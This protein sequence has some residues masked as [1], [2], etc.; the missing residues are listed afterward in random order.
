MI[1]SAAAADR[2]E[3]WADVIIAD[4]IKRR[5]RSYLIEI[6]RI[7]EWLAAVGIG[8]LESFLEFFFQN[9]FAVLHRRHF[10]CEKLL[11]QFFLLVQL[12]GEVFERA[13]DLFL[14]LMR[15]N[16]AGLGID[17]KGGFA[18]RTNYVEL[19]HTTQDYTS[20]PAAGFIF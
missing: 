4:A 10:L 16:G 15:E 3:D 11:A 12:A 14:F 13:V 7:F 2:R 20:L 8:P 1:R 19:L 17:R 5:E 18:A 6:E 9:A